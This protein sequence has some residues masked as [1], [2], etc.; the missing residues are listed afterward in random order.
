MVMIPGTPGNDNL[1]AK[2]MG[3]ELLGKEGNDTLDAV[4]AG[5]GSNILRGGVGDDELLAGTKDKLYGDEGN[6]ILKAEIGKGYN[7]LDGG[8][9][10]DTLRAGMNDQLMGGAEEDYLYAGQGNNTLEGGDSADLFWIAFG[11][12]PTQSNKIKD[13]KQ[14]VDKLGIKV[15]GITAENLL[16]KLKF[17]PNGQNTLIKTADDKEIAVLVG[18]QG[19]LTASDFTT[20][21]IT[22]APSSTPKADGGTIYAKGSNEKIVGTSGNDTLDAV[23]VGKGNNTLLGGMGDDQLLAGTNDKLYGGEGNDI[24]KAEV[25]KGGN[26]LDGG[27]GNDTLRAGK[28]DQLMGGAGQDYLYAGEGGNTLTGGTNAD[29]FWIA[30]G[31]LPAQPNIIKD[32]TQGRDKLGINVSGVEFKNLKFDLQGE[33]TVIMTADGKQIAVLAGFK[34]TIT[35]ADFASSLTPYIFA[36]D[37]DKVSVS[38]GNS[39]VIDVLGNDSGY[40]LAIDTFDATTAKGGKVSLSADG[41][42]LVYNPPS[43]IQ[44]GDVNKNFDLLLDSEQGIFKLFGQGQDVTDTFNYKVKDE[45]GN[46]KTS[47]VE[48]AIQDDAR[49]K[50]TLKAKEY[51][52]AYVNEIGVFKVAADGSING[53]KPGEAGYADAAIKSGDT[54]FSSPSSIGQKIKFDPTRVLDGFSGTDNLNFYLIQNDSS[55]NLLKG[56]T[57]PQVFFASIAGNQ[58]GKDNQSLNHLQIGTIPNDGGFKLKWEDLTGLGDADYND[59][60]VDVKLTNDPVVASANLQTGTEGELLDISGQPATKAKFEF[61]SYAGFN[62]T[63]DFYKVLDA[64]GTIKSGDTFLKP[65]DAGYAKAAVASSIN[66]KLTRDN[67]S[68]DTSLT[69]GS[70]FAPYLIANGTADE[71]LKSNGDNNPGGAPV[72][73][74]N[75]LGANPDKVDHVRSL[76]DN[77]FAFE[78]LPAN[79]GIAPDF[80]DVIVK[81]SLGV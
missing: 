1:F 25:G 77:I 49:V 32:F 15:D 60:V 74:F 67:K 11:G 50:F 41:S 47:P 35:E 43:T 27:T 81:A 26:L 53:I 6:D 42:K 54:L 46:V 28:N 20:D 36:A 21:A 31:G 44:H 78:D 19:T 51:D 40:G 16:Q 68:V 52:A 2:G 59:L 55:D 58:D 38:A 71:F 23:A 12:L 64:A 75:Y 5:K 80:E 62:N 66:L 48:V 22:L 14:G 45:D 65:G 63:V 69:E 8:V 9:G 73:Y 39:V 30:F 70:I 17:V 56:V 34:G 29:L 61:S 18:F 79:S 4:S 24:L 37:A 10:R 7:L 33:N 3:D 57:K 72:A 76:G 13:F